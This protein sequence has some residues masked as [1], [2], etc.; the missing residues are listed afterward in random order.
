[1]LE[2]CS[3]QQEKKEKEKEKKSEGIGKVRI[4]CS[5]KSSGIMVKNALT[6][7]RKTVFLWF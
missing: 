2:F 3:L 6:C 5:R 1:L 4:K 7:R